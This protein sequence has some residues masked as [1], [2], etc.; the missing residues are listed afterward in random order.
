MGLELDAV[1]AAGLVAAF[2]VVLIAARLVRPPVTAGLVVGGS[3]AVGLWLG[4]GAGVVVTGAILTL[5][6]AVGVVL[7]TGDHAGSGPR[8]RIGV[9]AG[10]P[11]VRDAIGSLHLDGCAVAWASSPADLAARVAA[12][13]VDVLLAD[14]DAQEVL[15]WLDQVRLAGPAEAPV[16]VPVVVRGLGPPA[17]A[18][19]APLLAAGVCG[20]IAPST[21]TAELARG[22]RAVADGGLV[23]PPSALASLAAAAPAPAEPRNPDGLTAREIDVLRLMAEGRSN[24][25]IAAALHVSQATV[26]TH[27]NR[28]FAKAAVRDRAQAVVYA[29]RTGMAPVPPPG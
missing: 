24:E 10:Q 14:G 17:P 27:I 2:A 13:P 19:W 8:V 16:V 5:G 12:E 23:L 15:G 20:V 4:G 29:F 6:A 28:I 21:T 18:S 7:R 9:V 25:E 26:K 22:L 1:H 3:V 11:V